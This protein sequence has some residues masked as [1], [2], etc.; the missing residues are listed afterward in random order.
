M[1]F[2]VCDQGGRSDV[3]RARY[4]GS[5]AQFTRSRESLAGGVATAF[6]AGQKPVPI[7]FEHGEGARLTDIDGNE[8]VDYV[9][10]FGPMLLGHSPELVIE[11]VERQLHRGIGF[12][13]SHRLE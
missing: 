8:Y 11:A 5:R 9:L 3:M 6:R 7:C 4:D 2:D 1:R 10:A 13:A 12:G